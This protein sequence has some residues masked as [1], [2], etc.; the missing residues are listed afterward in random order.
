MQHEI[1]R[2]GSGAFTAMARVRFPSWEF[3]E[4]NFSTNEMQNQKPLNLLSKFLSLINSCL[5]HIITMTTIQFF[6]CDYDDCLVYGQRHN[7][8]KETLNYFLWNKL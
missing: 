3:H 4:Q 6:F 5:P 7:T 8:S 1:H 2:L